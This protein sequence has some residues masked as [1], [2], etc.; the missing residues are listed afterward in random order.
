V[1]GC[2]TT[3]DPTQGGLF[4]W[5]EN[6]ARQR[7]QERQDRVVTEQNALS[8][9]AGTSQ[10]LEQKN[11]STDRQ[12]A[13]AQANHDRAEAR[14]K[15]QEAPLVAKTE[16][17]EAASPTSAGASRA[18]SYRRKVNTIVA[19]TALPAAQRSIR[20]QAIEAEVDRELEQLKR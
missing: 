15:S 16:Q 12:I 1:A 14:L 9:Q 2:D 8:A 19:Q 20:L 7:Q 3:G 13:I 5:S 6:K 11:A 4:G 17:L 18:R 10:S